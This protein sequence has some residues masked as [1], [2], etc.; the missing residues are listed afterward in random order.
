MRYHTPLVARLFSS[1]LLEDIACLAGFSHSRP[2]AIE[3]GR[4]AEPCKVYGVVS[5]IEV[6]VVHGVGTRMVISTSAAS[7]YPGQ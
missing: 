7:G 6:A 4:A 1:Q 3:A 5:R 2:I